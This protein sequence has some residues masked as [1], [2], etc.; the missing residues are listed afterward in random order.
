MKLSDHFHLHEFE[1]SQTATRL[2]ID[3]AIPH[4]LMENAKRMAQ[5]MEMVRS[6]LGNRPIIVSSGYRSPGLNTAIHGSKSSAHMQALACD[7]TCPTFGTVYQTA[8]LLASILDD[9]DQLIYEGTW[10]HI[11]LR[12]GHPRRELLTATFP[13]G[14]VH[15]QSG[16][17]KP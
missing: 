8:E 13:N 15:Y 7:F 14:K 2:G 10:I 6:I 11:G 17:I 16:L 4:E 1:I 5:T 3:N 12:D 9:Y